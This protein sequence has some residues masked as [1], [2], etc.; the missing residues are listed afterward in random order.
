[1]YTGLLHTHSGL[2]YLV[3]LLLVVVILKSLTAL[4]TNKPFGKLDDK[5]SLFL[6]IFTH[7][8]L[9]AG[10]VLYFV[11]GAVQF[12][13]ET[14]TTYRY[15]TVEHAVGMLVAVVLITVARATSK[16]MTNDT[17]KHRRLFVFNLLA[18]IIIVGIIL[19]S[20]RKLV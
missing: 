15:W 9:V 11:S 19:M 20:G 5:L 13:S 8:Q 12:G 6:L 18:L 14:M 10:L 17:H 4:L 1:M 7:L 16:R 2:R 3:L